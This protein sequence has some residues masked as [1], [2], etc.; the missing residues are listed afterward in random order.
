MGWQFA[1]RVGGFSP[2]Y[3]LHV[4]SC[5]GILDLGQW[6]DG[7]RNIFV[8]VHS[9]TSRVTEKTNSTELSRLAIAMI[10]V[11]FLCQPDIHSD[12]IF[13]R[14]AP[15]AGYYSLRRCC[16]AAEPS[17]IQRC[18]LAGGDAAVAGGARIAAAEAPY[19][20]ERTS[21]LAAERI[22]QRDEIIGRS[23][24]VRAVKEPPQQIASSSRPATPIDARPTSVRVKMPPGKHSPPLCGTIVRPRHRRIRMKRRRLETRYF[25]GG[26]ARISPGFGGDY[27][28]RSSRGC[29]IRVIGRT[30]NVSAR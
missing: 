13:F 12:L 6:C 9:A 22:E 23:R 17:P 3:S 19:A 1:G 28:P 4:N 24:Y 11:R 30:A 27:I 15:A 18:K 26:V 14:S 20:T 8:P 25:R 10:D 21:S 2:T 5:S 7:P 16:S 29:V